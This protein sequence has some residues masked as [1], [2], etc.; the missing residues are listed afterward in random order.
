MKPCAMNHMRQLLLS[1]MVLVLLPAIGTAADLTERQLK[2][3]SS[4]CIQCHA[5]PETGAPLMGS[6]DQWVE[7]VKRGQDALLRSLILGT[8]G[9]PPG[10]YCM[11]CD[12][13]DFRAL[14]DQMTGLGSQ[15]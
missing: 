3:L 8:P 6:P 13:A 1:G 9:M 5:R 11:A 4:S 12:E 10:G 7:R 2:L 14:I 15:K